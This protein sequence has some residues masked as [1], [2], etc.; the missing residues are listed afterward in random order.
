MNKKFIFAL[1]LIGFLKLSAQSS[2]LAGDSLVYAQ[3]QVAAYVKG[4]FYRSYNFGFNY[5]RVAAENGIG[6]IMAFTCQLDESCG[7]AAIGYWNSLGPTFEE[8]IK[9]SLIK[10]SKVYQAYQYE[11]CEDIVLTDTLNFAVSSW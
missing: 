1:L 4:V 6:G 3:G 5:P 9:S 10:I 8:S 2:T 11:R 7:V